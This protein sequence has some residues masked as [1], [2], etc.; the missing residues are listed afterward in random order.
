MCAYYSKAPWSRRHS[1][2]LGEGD[3]LT[4]KRIKISF[5]QR[6][7]DLSEQHFPSFC[8]VT[9]SHVQ[10][11]LKMC[12]SAQ[13]GLG[14]TAR[15]RQE[16]TCFLA[17]RWILSRGLQESSS[18]M[19]WSRLGSS[20]ELDR[21][22]LLKGILP[23]PCFCTSI[24]VTAPMA[25]LA[26]HLAR[27]GATAWKYFSLRGLGPARVTGNRL[28]HLAAS[29]LGFFPCKESSWLKPGKE[30]YHIFLGFL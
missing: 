15:I 8:A 10:G 6:P 25:A 5:F 30:H 27:E 22:N 17:R 1:Q 14:A 3:E 9:A 18:R 24:S 16:S 21:I 13:S 4:A 2:D 7:C 28:G 20:R 19:I 12:T 11:S 23:E 29:V 26:P